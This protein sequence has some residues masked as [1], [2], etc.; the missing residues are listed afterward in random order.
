MRTHRARPK[1][2]PYAL[3]QPLLYSRSHSRSLSRLRMQVLI[4][5]PADALDPSKE[6]P[7]GLGLF[8][9]HI[10]IPSDYPNA[11][12]LVNLQTTGNGMVRFNPNLYSDGKVCLSLLGTWHGE[13]W[14]VPTAS[15]SGSTLLQ[16]T[17][18][19]CLGTS[20]YK[21]N[22]YLLSFVFVSEK[23]VSE[24]HVSEKIIQKKA[25]EKIISAVSK[26]Y[27]I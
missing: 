18:I 26:P 7:Y 22:L 19:S 10:F 8:E 17:M 16:V 15:N 24:K 6:T 9:F 20:S 1:E 5:G 12:P 23:H 14:I 13:G 21:T 27:P 3:T 25:S 2:A 11:P 4:S